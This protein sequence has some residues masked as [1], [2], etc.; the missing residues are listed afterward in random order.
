MGQGPRFTKKTNINER[1][2]PVPMYDT[3][4]AIIANCENSSSRDN[5]LASHCVQPI[6]QC[7]TSDGSYMWYLSEPGRSLSMRSW[8]IIGCF[9]IAR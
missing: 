9:S 8:V 1:I 3:V 4:Q 5:L 7:N 6:V 2:R